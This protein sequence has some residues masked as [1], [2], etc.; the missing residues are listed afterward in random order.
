MKGVKS[1]VSIGVEFIEDER[2][3]KLSEYRSGVYRRWKEWKSNEG[4][5]ARVSGVDIHT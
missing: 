1:W 3:E 4:F 2:S 5:G